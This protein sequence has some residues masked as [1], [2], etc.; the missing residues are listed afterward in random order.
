MLFV[1]EIVIYS[2]LMGQ[3]GDQ[4]EFPLE[5]KFTSTLKNKFLNVTAL[6]L[7]CEYWPC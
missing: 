6:N 2:H 5:I 1:T 3:I 4:S 7:T